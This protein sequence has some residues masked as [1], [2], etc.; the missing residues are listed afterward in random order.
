MIATHILTDFFA[1]GLLL[2]TFLMMGKIRLVPMLRYFILASIFLGGLS[3][4]STHLKGET[5][6]L[7]AI[8]TILFKAVLI[9]GVIYFTAKKLPTSNVLRTYVKP[10]TTQILFA[11]LLVISAIIVRNIPVIETS[12]GENIFLLKGLFFVSVALILT[13]ILLTII[14]RDLFSQVLGILTMENGISTFALVALDGIPLFLEIGIFFV[15]VTS[16]VILANLI[17]KVHAEYRIGDTSNLN[18]LIN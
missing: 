10:G 17:D 8:A 9:P 13:G 5:D 6:F 14:R 11:L 15:I 1:A 7:P 12:I 4:A 3:A 2:S 18:E 16:T